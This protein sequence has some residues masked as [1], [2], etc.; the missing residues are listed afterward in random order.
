MKRCYACKSERLRAG[1][2]TVRR[3]FGGRAFEVKN[4][5]ALV[6]AKCGEFTIDGVDL[7]RAENAITAELARAGPMTGDA[8]KWLRKAIALKA[9]EIGELLDVAPETIS[10]WETGERPPDRAAWLMLGTMALEMLEGRSQ[11][12]DRLRDLKA[13]PGTS[14]VVRL[15]LRPA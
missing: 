5:P 12:I 10:R 13:R 14:K 9:T 7:V 8:F 1:Q 3:E 11:T 6:C 2:T 15:K 4:V